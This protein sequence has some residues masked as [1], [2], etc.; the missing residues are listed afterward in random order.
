MIIQIYNNYA[1]FKVLPASFIAMPLYLYFPPLIDCI[2]LYIYIVSRIA[3]NLLVC[4]C[5]LSWLARWLRMHPTLAL[6]TK[7]S[8]PAQY[9][10][11][12]IAE[13]QEANFKCEGGNGEFVY[14]FM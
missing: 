2:Y 11:V 12:E 10:N 6:F 9:K 1:T 3:D 4:N 14:M 13:L 5:H 8:A 7:C